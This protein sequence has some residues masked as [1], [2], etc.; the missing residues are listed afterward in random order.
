MAPM[1]VSP[2]SRSAPRLTKRLLALPLLLGVLAAGACAPGAEEGSEGG[3][4]T[5][6]PRVENEELGIALAR[7]PSGFEVVENRGETLVLGRTGDDPARLTVEL[8]PVQEAGVNL[9]D[10][11][12]E[13]KARIESLPEGVYRGQNE[14]GGVPIG[15]TFTSRGR[16]VNEE[17]E[18]VEEYRALAVH[19]TE[20]RVLILDYEYPVPP[21]GEQEDG[22]STRLQE[23]MLVLEQVEAAGGSADQEAAATS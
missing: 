15:T 18:R 9:V 13:E 3:E 4:A 20:N 12:W 11:V 22:P 16:F 14:L 2:S 19:P 6:R 1:P 23:L 8:G 10:R 21:P 7:L 17:G 5:S